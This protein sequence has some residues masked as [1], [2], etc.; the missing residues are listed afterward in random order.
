MKQLALNAPK[1]NKMVKW[2]VSIIFFSFI[3]FNIIA[4]STT[5]NLTCT[6]RLEKAQELYE[7]GRI[8]E[9]EDMLA[10]CVKTIYDEKPDISPRG[11]RLTTLEKEEAYRLLINSQLYLNAEKRSEAW[12]IRLLQN[13][14]EYRL[15]SDDIQEFINLYKTMKTTPFLILGGR[16]GANLSLVESTRTYSLD[17]P[18]AENIGTYTAGYGYNIGG[19]AT[20]PINKFIDLT[21]EVGLQSNSYQYQNTFFD[22]SNLSFRETITSLETPLYIKI[23]LGNKYNFGRIIKPFI[24]GGGNFNLLLQSKA[25][26][27][28]QDQVS[29]T[30]QRQVTGPNVITTPLRQANI[31]SVLFGA[32]V[33]Y[34]NSR[35]SWFMDFR[36]VINFNNMV[37]TQNRYNNPELLF[38]Y[39][40]VDNDFLLNNVRVSVGYLYPFY[41]P[42]P[43]RGKKRYDF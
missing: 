3:S 32:G 39:G 15:Q 21:L 8:E 12:M 25:K 27:E 6:E 13:N 35:G 14:P 10:P 7:Q 11:R 20:L 40:Y 37:N 34:K 43:K 23:Y 28:R 36:Y 31:F 29:S 33:E 16:V 22:Y 17:R 30:I 4:Q 18:N 19:I 9:V 2:I 42:K 41:N 5:E 24:L 38:R 26:V 1:V